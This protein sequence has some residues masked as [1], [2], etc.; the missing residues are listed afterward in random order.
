MNAVLNIYKDCTSEEPT[1]Q[2]ICKRLLFGASQ[3]IQ[4][5]SK[6][7]EGKSEEEQKELNLDILKTIF[8]HFVEEDFDFIDTLEWFEFVNEIGR[9]TS[10]VVNL[11]AKK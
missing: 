11:A 7:M 2:Y 5:I 4:S 10:K 8:P 6:D 1:K 9:E 3:K